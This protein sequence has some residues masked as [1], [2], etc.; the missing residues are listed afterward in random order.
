[1]VEQPEAASEDHTMGSERPC[2]LARRVE[3]YQGSSSRS[4]ACSACPGYSIIVGEEKFFNHVESQHP[5]VVVELLD[6]A[7]RSAFLTKA[8]QAA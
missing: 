8:E 5:E 3:D 7:C 2:F 4:L 6:D 1:M